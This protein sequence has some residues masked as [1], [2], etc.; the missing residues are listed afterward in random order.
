MPASALAL[1]NNDVVQIVWRLDQ[2]IPG[3]LGLAVYR[4]EGAPYAA[5]NWVPLPAWVGFVGQSNLA[6]TR[7][8]TEIWPVQKFEWKD[9]TAE[10]GKTY[11]YKI[12]PV[13]GDPASAA[14]LTQLTDKT[15]IAGP[16][17]LTPTRGSFNSFFNRGILSTQ[18]LAHSV[19]AGPKGA[20]NFKIL[21]D[22]I[23][24]LGD[25]LRTALAGQ[26][27]EGLES[28][29]KR[30]ASEGGSVYAALYELTDPELVQILLQN[31]KSLHLI[32]SNTGTDDKENEAA[33]Q[34]LHDAGAD[35]ID[36]FV[37]SG[38]IGHNKFM[39]YADA[40]GA[41][42][43]VLLGSTNWT[44]T[45]ICAQAN[46]TLV[47][48]SPQLAQT[49]M[50]YWQ[51]LKDDAE[52]AQAKRGPSLRD[53]DAHPGAIDIKIDKGLATV[54]FSPN[55]PHARR[56]H[57]GAGE[58]TPPDMQQ[59]FELM[60][61]A[62]Q[63]ILFLVFQRGSPSIVDH[64]AAAANSRTDLFVRGAATDPKAADVYNT[65]LIHRA[66][67][68]PVEVVPASAIT[69]QFAC[70]QHELL[71]SGPQAHAI[72]HDK[73]VVIDPMSDDCVVITGSHNLG[74]RASYNNDENLLI[75]RGHKALAQAYAVHVLDIYD[76]HRFRYVIQ[77][78]GTHAFSGLEPDDEWQDKYFDTTS[79]ASHDADVWFGSDDA[80]NVTPQA[81]KAP[82]PV[83]GPQAKIGRP[84]RPGRAR[85]A[86]PA[87]RRRK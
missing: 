64:A 55:T 41:P 5:G 49:Y 52:Q 8:T 24:Q 73:I 1:A 9:L 74:Y 30:A 60:D 62:K 54:W 57:P 2:K 68:S 44:D 46:N 29:L 69:D 31:K 38:H 22:R 12:V 70:W 79:A 26:I 28:L 33:R 82:P 48:Q 42:Q 13:T 18:F 14:K 58:A 6:W 81:M 11:S 66:G 83:A 15:L 72:I 39:I 32:L 85:P 76:H 40:S 25:P 84:R 80:G 36:R 71:K 16:A 7:K 43:A 35:I 63:A 51:R 19:P 27:L 23:D 59:V 86:A 78:Q 17:T 50:R 45:A 21:T 47:V 77:K 4:K 34:S 87:R 67:E 3:C 65:L 61:A 10:R 20:P 53:A 75:V 56:S 37:P